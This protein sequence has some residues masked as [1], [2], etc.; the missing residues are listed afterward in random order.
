[1]SP[2]LERNFDPKPGKVQLLNLNNNFP[3]IYTT[4]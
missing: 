3:T 1:M 4:V 2:K